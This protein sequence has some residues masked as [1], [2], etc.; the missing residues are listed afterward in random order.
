MSLFCLLTPYAYDLTRATN[1]AGDDTHGCRVT[2]SNQRPIDT[3]S[4]GCI[5]DEIAETMETSSTSLYT[6]QCEMKCF[7]ML[8]TPAAVKLF[9]PGFNE[10]L[11]MEMK[12]EK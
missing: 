8:V 3:S 5:N 7:L 1:L 2:R 12:E 6:E 4:L 11:D 9:A 10:I